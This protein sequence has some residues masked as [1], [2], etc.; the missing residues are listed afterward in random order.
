MN[1]IKIGNEYEILILG[2]VVDQILQ[3]VSGGK[4]M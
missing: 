4:K 1:L 2:F 3:L